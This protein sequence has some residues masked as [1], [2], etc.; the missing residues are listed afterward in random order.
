VEVKMWVKIVGL[1]MMLV[2]PL[3]PQV[4]AEGINGVWVKDDGATKQSDWKND[5]FDIEIYECGD[6]QCGKIIAM[7]LPYEKGGKYYAESGKPRVDKENKE[8]I[9]MRVA[10]NIEPTGKNKWRGRMYSPGLGAEAP[11]SFSLVGN[12][13][14]ARAYV[15]KFI[16]T[17][18]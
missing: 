8:L 1:T 10:W 7:S 4:N 16:L 9:G 17:R 15:K 18:K 3:A 11:V 6:Y 12:T 2:L 13:I 14:S 5:K